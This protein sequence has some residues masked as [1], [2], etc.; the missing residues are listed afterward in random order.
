MSNAQFSECRTEEL[1]KSFEDL[2]ATCPLREKLPL[3]IE[4]HIKAQAKH[5]IECFPRSVYMAWFD[6]EMKNASK[7]LDEMLIQGFNEFSH[8]GSV[9]EIYIWNKM[10]AKALQDVLNEVD[11][12]RP[13]V[14]QDRSEEYRF[15]LKEFIANEEYSP[16]PNDRYAIIKEQVEIRWGRVKKAGAF[17]SDRTNWKKGKVWLTKDLVEAIIRE[18]EEE[19]RPIDY[20]YV[21]QLQFS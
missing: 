15:V 11:T 7:V 1:K 8:K 21:R 13:E 20:A 9:T 16:Y 18:L 12:P 10:R 14:P 17:K 2:C 6:Q 3:A 19:G 4:E 5:Q